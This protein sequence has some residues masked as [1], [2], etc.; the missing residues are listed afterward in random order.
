[1]SRVLLIGEVD[2][3]WTFKCIEKTGLSDDNSIYLYDPFPNTETKKYKDLGVKIIDDCHLRHTDRKNKIQTLKYVTNYVSCI[4][5][6]SKKHNSFDVVHINYA[7]MEKILSIPYLR[8]ISKKLVVTFWGSDLFR[9]SDFILKRYK[10]Y[11]DKVDVITLSTNEMVSRF[12]DVYGDRYDSKLQ[13]IRFGVDGFNYIDLFNSSENSKSFFDLPLDKTIITIGYNGNVAQ[14]HLKVIDELKLLPDNLQ[15]KLFII[16][17]A[18]YGLN[19]EY[20]QN[21]I[22]SLD[23]LV[24]DYRIFDK[25]MSDEELGQLRNATDYFIHS[26][27]TDALS[28]SVQE[29]LYARKIVFNPTW[30]VYEDFDEVGV[31][32]EKY[33]SFIELRQLLANHIETGINRET[34]SNLIKNSE[35]LSNLT[36]WNVVS[37]KWRELYSGL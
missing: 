32:Y 6:L 9:V 8:K 16:I 11:F 18:T 20:K 34:E 22:D 23:E 35:I 31:Y 36:S 29:Y 3:I 27:I 33:G 19:D 2:S 4:K 15:K 17:P 10:A 14:Q 13:R 37:S 25:F 24:C 12:H 1:M 7:S 28:A 21:L 26:Q 30:I 5:M